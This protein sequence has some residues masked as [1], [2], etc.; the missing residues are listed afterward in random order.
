VNVSATSSTSVSKKAVCESAETGEDDRHTERRS[1]H[2]TEYARVLALESVL[3]LRCAYV[4]F[5]APAF[6]LSLFCTPLISRTTENLKKD[7][8]TFGVARKTGSH[9]QTTNPEPGSLGRRH[10]NP[11]SRYT[12]DTRHWSCRTVESVA[13]SFAVIIYISI[14]YIL[15][16]KTTKVDERCP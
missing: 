13:V 7:T 4:Q 9:S 6:F 10:E 2:T 14:S 1:A 11:P 5:A 15:P 3:L 8:W 12:F 16:T